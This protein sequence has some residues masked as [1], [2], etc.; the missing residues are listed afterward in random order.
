MGTEGKEI[1]SLSVTERKK[2][3]VKKMADNGQIGRV[4]DS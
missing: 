3:R 4:N 1:K 2:E